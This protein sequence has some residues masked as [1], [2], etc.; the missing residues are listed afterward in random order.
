MRLNL[1]FKIFRQLI[2]EPDFMSFEKWIMVD[3][4][5]SLINRRKSR[6]KISKFDI[7]ITNFP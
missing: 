6:K 1:V 4:N 2:L 5:N 7:I 3:S